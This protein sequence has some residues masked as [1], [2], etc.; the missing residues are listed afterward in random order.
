MKYRK[1]TAF[2]VED[3]IVVL[4][5]EDGSRALGPV[6]RC[7]AEGASCACGGS[8]CE[9]ATEVAHAFDDWIEDGAYTWSTDT[10]LLVL[11][12][13]FTAAHGNVK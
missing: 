8:N 10:E 6:F 9:S 11:A 1:L 2:D 3:Q 5:A 4:L 7:P 13:A 12:G